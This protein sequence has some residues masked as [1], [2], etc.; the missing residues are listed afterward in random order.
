MSINRRDWLTATGLTAVTGLTAKLHA[1]ES[2]RSKKKLDVRYCI[3]TS[4]VREQ[5]LSL[6]EEVRLAAEVGYNGIEPW[7][8]EIEAF[9]N[10]GKPLAELKKQIADAGM[11]VES[12]IGFARWI[13][14]DKAEREK[15][16]EQMKRDME[17]VRSIGGTRI[18]AP[19]VGMHGK[20]SPNVD[21]FAAAERYHALL[22]IGQEI[23][24]TPQVE[25]WGP[26]KNL[27]RLGE[28]IFVAVESGHP[29]AC[30]LPDVYHIF[31]GGSDFAGLG[32]LSGDA[33]KCFH[34][35]DYPAEPAREQMNDSDRVYPGDGVAPWKEII[36]ILNAI[37]FQ[38]AVS[39]ELFNRDYWKQ[40][41]RVVLETGLKKM[42]DVFELNS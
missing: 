9:Q 28:A 39:L 1:A 18:A 32:L 24:V 14:D 34:F 27:S 21:L 23:G 22:E 17:L 30:V 40:D 11:Q 41:A 12:A 38:G 13:V 7:I 25:I 19:P 20:D 8:R 35:N 37:G 10:S 6:D 2:E 15:G 29:N 3:N 31:R 36:G 5:K 16:L 33:I 42:K 26:S 4:T